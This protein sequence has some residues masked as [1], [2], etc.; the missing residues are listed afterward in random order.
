MNP[1]ESMAAFLFS[2]TEA[3]RF[4]RS[5]LADGFSE[6]WLQELLFR[7]PELLPLQQIEPGAGKF[8]PVCRELSLPRAGGNVYL[9]VFGITSSGRPVLV[10]CK[11]WRNPQA[12]REVIAQILEYSALLRRWGYSDLTARIKKSSASEGQNPLYDLVHAQGAAMAEADFVDAVSRN[13]RSGDFHLIIVG[14]GIR[15]DASAIVE[16]VAGIGARLAIVEMQRW[17]DSAGNQLL[18]PQV[19]FRT[20]VVRQRIL[21]DSAGVPLI[22]DQEESI[23][24]VVPGV[25]DPEKQAVR[26]SNREFWQE[27][28]DSARFDHPDQPV[29]RH[30][31]NNWVKVPMPDPARWLNVYRYKG[32]AAMSLVERDG[33][34]L[35]DWL[36]RDGASLQS[37][38]G[39]EPIILHHEGHPDRPMICVV[40]PQAG[41]DQMSWLQD[42]TNR[43]VTL[44]RPR[45]VEFKG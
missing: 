11:L 13:L 31:G 30:G 32:R 1:G 25:I 20:E 38:F 24:E 37:E 45:I 17:R 42:A 29:P 19:P 15:E 4:E 44:L 5:D 3:T 10:E 39:P 40:Q 27:Y 12:R 28:I 21:V 34:G 43:M 18:L 7:E 23:D 9:D 33:S 35:L 41:E 6:S 14:D 16:H 8:I 26:E 22:A 36:A 2:K